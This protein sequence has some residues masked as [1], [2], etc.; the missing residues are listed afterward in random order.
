[1]IL[2][3][4]IMDHL[5]L[6]SAFAS[7]RHF[8][9]DFSSIVFSLVN[10]LGNFFQFCLFEEFAQAVAHPMIKLCCFSVAGTPNKKQDDW[11]QLKS[12]HQQENA[13]ALHPNNFEN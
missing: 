5:R 4:N 2:T 8:N 11:D 12:K 9:T 3:D 13:I 7:C 6:E 10:L 1:M